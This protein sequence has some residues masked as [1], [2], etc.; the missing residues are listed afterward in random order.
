M[1]AKNFSSPG[2]VAKLPNRRAPV[3]NDEWPK[4][5]KKYTFKAVVD[6]FPFA[7]A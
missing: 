4:L 7:A 2:W 6:P 5:G 1:A 3:T